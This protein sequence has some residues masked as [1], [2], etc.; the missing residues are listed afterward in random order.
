[1]SPH[2]D[3]V[4]IQLTSDK[5]DSNKKTQLSNNER[6]SHRLLTDIESGVSADPSARDKLK[7][8]SQILLD[9]GVRKST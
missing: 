4:S 8:H 6:T 1:M 5:K 3:S 7:T 9:G 2:A